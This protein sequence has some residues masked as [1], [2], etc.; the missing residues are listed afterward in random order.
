MSSWEALTVLELISSVHRS[1]PLWMKSN[2]AWSGLSW[3]KKEFYQTWADYHLRFLDLMAERNFPLWAISTGNE[4]LNGVIGFLFIQFMSLGWTANDQ[5]HWL[6]NNFGP[7]IRNSKHRSIKIFGS[8]DQR[9]VFP[10]WFDRMDQADSKATSFLDGLAVHW[11]WDDVAPPS[12]LDR[13]HEKYPDKI[14]LNTESCVGD[15]PLQTHGPELGSWERAEH[16]ITAYIED[17]NHW[18]N[19]WVDW[20]LLLD[21]QGGPNYVKNFVDAAIIVNTTSRT[22]FYKQPIFYAIG[23]FS[24]FLPEGSLKIQVQ[25]SNKNVV[26]TGFQ[27]PDGSVAVI[28][29]NKLV[30]NINL[31]FEDPVR[32]AIQFK[33]PPKSIHTLIYL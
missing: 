21:E 10:W 20:N 29:Y 6:A 15:K 4:P 32:G 26:V 19:G 11:Y 12:L 24:R 3:L 16:Y 28:F 18:V 33:I 17:L 30:K 1:P 5:G 13:T 23:H 9:Y 8:D 27:R 22:E 25:S 7:T 14:I 2:G 31:K